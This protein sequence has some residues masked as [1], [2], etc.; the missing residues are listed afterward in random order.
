VLS[1]GLFVFTK[2]PPLGFPLGLVDCVVDGFVVGFSTGVFHYIG[3]SL[4]IQSISSFVMHYWI[5]NHSFFG[6][7]VA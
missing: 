1:V 4:I 3:Q 6:Y 7:L 2:G 5:S